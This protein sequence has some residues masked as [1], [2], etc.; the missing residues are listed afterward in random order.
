MV[1]PIAHMFREASV[2]EHLGPVEQEV[3]VIEHIL[4]LLA[5]T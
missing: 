3:I 2:A 4:S 5:S 1:E